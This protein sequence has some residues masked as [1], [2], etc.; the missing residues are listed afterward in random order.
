MQFKIVIILIL[1]VLAGCKEIEST[2]IYNKEHVLYLNGY[3]RSAERFKSETK[4]AAG[5][6]R[7]YKEHINT[8][9]TQGHVDLAAFL[10][11]EVIETGYVLNEK[12]DHYNQI[13]GYILESR[14]GI[15]GGYLEFN[16]EV[17]QSDGT[18]RI[19]SGETTSMFN[20]MEINENPILG[21]IKNHNNK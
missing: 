3:G 7:F 20:S 18:I 10:D 11:E 21:H 15:I 17:E 1:L 6:L 13:V 8:I 9:Q 2:E 14:D 12:T 4:Y 5:T 16:K 19:D